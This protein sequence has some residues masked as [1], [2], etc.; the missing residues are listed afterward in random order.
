MI[1]LEKLPADEAERLAYAEG[2]VGTARLF[3]RIDDLQRALGA[4]VAEV[5]QLRQDLYIAQHERAYPRDDG[6]WPH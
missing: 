3:A 2:F 6:T 4:A 1:D 5:E